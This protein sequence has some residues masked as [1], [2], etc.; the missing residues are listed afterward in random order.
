MTSA[1]TALAD[2]TNWRTPRRSQ[3]ENNCV[4]IGSIPGIVGVRDTKLGPASPILA[5]TDTAFAALITAAKT[6]R[7]DPL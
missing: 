7:L 1:H 4:E 3:G 2:I 5:F 6:S